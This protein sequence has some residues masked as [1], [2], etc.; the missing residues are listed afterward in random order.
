MTKRF[1]SILSCLLAVLLLAAMLPM[2]AAAAST[3]FTDVADSD[4]FANPVLWAVE[5]GITNGISPTQFGPNNP[6]TRAQVVTFLWAAE[7]KP[8]PNS[9]DNPFTDVPNDAWYVKPVLWAVERGITGGT[10]P[11]TF[12]PDAECTRAQIV[13]FLYA[14]AGK[15]AVSA[16]ESVFIDVTSSDWFLTPVLWA[17][18]NDITGG[19]GPDTFGPLNVCTRGQVV[20]FLFKAYDGTVPEVT[21]TPEPT[22]EVT[23]TPELPVDR[24]P[25]MSMPSALTLDPGQSETIT[26]LVD[27]GSYNG[28]LNLVYQTSYS[29]IA[30]VQWGEFTETSREL[31]V[32]AYNPGTVDITITM[33]DEGGNMVTSATLTVTV[34]GEPA[35]N[36]ER[37]FEA[38]KYFI[39]INC[40]SVVDGTYIYSEIYEEEN[41]Q[42]EIALMYTPGEP[43]IEIC[44]WTDVV[45][46][47][48]PAYFDTFLF[49]E[50]NFLTSYAGIYFYLG[51][52]SDA[53]LM[54]EGHTDIWKN[55]FN[56]NHNISFYES[57]GDTANTATYAD[58]LKECTMSAL[59]YVDELLAQHLP[60][61]SIADFGYTN[62]YN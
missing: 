31:I 59:T 7:G 18:E 57:H 35:S 49:L 51:E 9:T 55:E 24:D 1:R 40:T 54:F 47:G 53:N 6:C 20:T 14:A 60:E 19:T 32:T 56:K 43:N 10:S 4:W 36:G 13:T 23:P 61:F 34:T 58:F 3:P 38:L 44:V 37:A 5:K 21:P 15:P 12:S 2:T 39:Q 30:S 27:K 42:V 17:K 25:S 48:I 52:Y 41:G 11:T 22:P 28:N 29:D 45:V 46:G 50:H 33:G 62:I 8:E 16:T 26:V